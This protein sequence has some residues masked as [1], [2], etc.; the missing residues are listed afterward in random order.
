MRIKPGIKQADDRASDELPYTKA[1][2]GSR[3]NFL[4]LQTS[5]YVD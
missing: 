1:N 4:G 2:D 3:E 5:S